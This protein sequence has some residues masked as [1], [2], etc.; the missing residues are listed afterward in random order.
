VRSILA[1]FIATW[2]VGCAGAA[3][4]GAEQPV[5][6]NNEPQPIVD[7]SRSDE[8]ETGFRIYTVDDCVKIFEIADQYGLSQQTIVW[9]NPGLLEGEAENMKPG[10]A[11]LIPTEEGTGYTWQ[12]GDTTAAVAATLGVSAEAIS[13]WPGN[14][15]Y[16]RGGSFAPEPGEVIYIPAP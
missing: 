7:L 4:P 15:V 10:M 5:I 2:L 1:I 6:R 13:S 3:S 8:T 16:L 14:E 12:A 11:L 9:A